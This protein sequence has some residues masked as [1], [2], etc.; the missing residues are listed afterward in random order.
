MAGLAE[1]A[2]PHVLTL[3][4]QALNQQNYLSGPIKMCYFYNGKKKKP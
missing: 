4:P 2:Q 1:S 3:V